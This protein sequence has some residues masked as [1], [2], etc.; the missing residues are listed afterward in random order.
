LKTDPTNAP[1]LTN[2]GNIYYD[3]YDAKQYPLAIQYYERSLQAQPADA[4]VRKDLGTT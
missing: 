3:Y 4:S 1:L 2:L